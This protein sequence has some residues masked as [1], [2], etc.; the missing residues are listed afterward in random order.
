MLIIAGR[1]ANSAVRA[2]DSLLAETDLPGTCLVTVSGEHVGT[3]ANFT[4]RPMREG[5][6][7]VLIAP[8]AGG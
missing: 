1:P 4:D 3:V 7:L 6:E 8:V 2:V 5:E